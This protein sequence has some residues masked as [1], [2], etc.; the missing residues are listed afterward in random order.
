MQRET[1]EAF[2]KREGLEVYQI[3]SDDGISGYTSDRRPALAAL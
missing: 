2:A 3:Y 1:L